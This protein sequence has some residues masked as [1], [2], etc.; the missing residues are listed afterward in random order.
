MADDILSRVKST[1]SW[2]ADDFGCSF[3]R[4]DSRC[5]ELRNLMFLLRLR[6][7]GT[8]LPTLHWVSYEHGEVDLWEFFCRKRPSMIERCKV[9]TPATASI[10]ERETIMISVLSRALQCAGMDIIN[11]EAPS[12]LSRRA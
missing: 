8:D 4:R 2:L 3:A 7:G 10:A 6:H 12:E 1:F 9:H 11:G 5:I